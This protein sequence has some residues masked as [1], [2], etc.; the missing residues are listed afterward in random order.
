MLP[1]E[2]LY[3]TNGA[4]SLR[5]DSELTLLGHGP[6]GLT[7][8][9]TVKKRVIL[10]VFSLKA[11]NLAKKNLDDDQIETRVYVH[12]ATLPSQACNYIPAEA[13]QR[14]KISN[15]AGTVEI[16]G[17]ERD[18]QGETACCV[19]L[20][21]GAVDCA[22]CLREEWSSIRDSLTEQE[23]NVAEKILDVVRNRGEPGITKF[24]LMVS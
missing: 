11:I 19:R 20:T 21:D 15:V 2:L 5:L 14:S 24:D 7:W 6:L 1:S 17:H 3:A 13:Q 4:I 23:R 12:F 16:Y 10:H 9:G 18:I 8:T 22:S